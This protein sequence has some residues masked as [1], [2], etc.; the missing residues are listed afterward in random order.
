MFEWT[1]QAPNQ[2]GPVVSDGL[3]ELSIEEDSNKSLQFR[4]KKP[5]EEPRFL[6]D[7]IT[8]FNTAISS[9]GSADLIS[10][11]TLGSFYSVLKQSVARRLKDLPA[12]CKHCVSQSAHKQKFLA[13]NKKCPHAKVGVLFS[14]G[15]DSAVLAALA[16][17]CLAQDEE[18]DLLNV[19]FEKQ[20][21]DAK[22]KGESDYSVPD[23]INGLETLKELNP[24]RKW[25]FVEINVT[26]DELR[27]QRQSII[28]RL[29]YPLQT[30]LDDSIGCAVWFASR[31]QGQLTGTNEPYKSHAEVLLLGMGADEQLADARPVEHELDGDG[32]TQRRDDRQRELRG[33]RDH[34]VAHHVLPHDLAL[35]EPEGPRGAD[36]VAARDVDHGGAGDPAQLFRNL[37]R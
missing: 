30:V 16:D 36:I 31:G 28:K 33:D 10:A 8:P 7:T 18:V 20:R 21:S 12:T 3:E 9:R 5:N 14:G 15:V 6:G 26:L 29:L 22:S 35:A 25:N 17:Q 23:R 37:A 11:E 4:V 1:H 2:E 32:A 24:R 27:V 13:E 19:A 34:G